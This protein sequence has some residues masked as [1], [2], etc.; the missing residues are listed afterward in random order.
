MKSRTA[1]SLL[2]LLYVVPAKSQIQAYLIFTSGYTNT[3]RTLDG[4]LVEI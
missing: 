2:L 4:V 3:H 1:L